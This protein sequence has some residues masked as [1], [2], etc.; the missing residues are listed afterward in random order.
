MLLEQP[1]RRTRAA[2]PVP[3]VD[4]DA[5]HEPLTEE[6]ERAWSRV[7]QSRSF[8]GGFEVAAFEQDWAEY[9]GTKHAIGVGNGT[10]AIT[11]TL[12]ALGIGPGDE[13]ILPT[14]TFVATAEAIVL[15]GARPRFVDVDPQTLLVTTEHV[16]AAMNERTAAVIIVHLYGNV[17]DAEAI[18]DA[19]ARRGIPVIE[20]AAQAHGAT[21]RGRRAGSFGVAGCFS[22]YPAKNLGA[23]GD[24][25]AVITNDGELADRLRSAANHGRAHGSWYE[26]DALGTNSRL[27][28]LQAAFLAVKLPHLDGWNASRRNIARMYR[29]LLLG[30]QCEIVREPDETEGVHHL[31]VAR[32][33][34]RDRV[35]DLLRGRGIETGVHYPVPCHMQP[36]FAGFA[37]EPLTVAERAASEIVS[38][39]MFPTMSPTQM[40][41]V[42]LALRDAV[43]AKKPSRRRR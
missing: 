13:V 27:D 18:V 31:L 12:R 5:L 11:L 26:H 6:L 3:F 23:L 36:P 14:N 20:D 4:L 24:G 1:R 9:C 16:E 38:L 34:D 10:D 7:L 29:K 2:E 17:A 35:R 39:P 40:E 25:G 21:L 33:A 41:R 22:F 30:T 28:A 37:D 8:I 19:A 15:T 42:A 43:G 32:V